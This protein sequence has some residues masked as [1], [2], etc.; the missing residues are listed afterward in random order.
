M[1]NGVKRGKGKR[2]KK[3]KKG[4]RGLKL[5]S[6]ELI[7]SKFFCGGAIAPP[8]PPLNVIQHHNVSNKHKKL[9]ANGKL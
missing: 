1:K 5:H 4:K 8:A 3:R 6:I 9:V 2:E 7:G